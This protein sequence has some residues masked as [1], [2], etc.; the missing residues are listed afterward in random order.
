M[1]NQVI[2]NFNKIKPRSVGNIGQLLLWFD[3]EKFLYYDQDNPEPNVYNK[4]Y[5]QP[6]HE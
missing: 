4:L 3:K 6:K 2:I 1:H 5:A